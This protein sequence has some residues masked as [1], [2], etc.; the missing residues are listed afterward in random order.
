MGVAV[1]CTLMASDFTTASLQSS[2]P[3]LAMSRVKAGVG[4]SSV[5]T[6]LGD[7]GEIR[8]ARKDEVAH[9][10]GDG[11]TVVDNR[12]GEPAEEHVDVV[13]Q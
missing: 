10:R 6:G 7:A 13:M 1:F 11:R 2:L 4:I 3:L 12:A 9:K 5:Q 8:R